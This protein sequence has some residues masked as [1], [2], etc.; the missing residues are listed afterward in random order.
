[1][2]NNIG[3]IDATICEL[4]FASVISS[5]SL[6]VRLP[7]NLGL[8]RE[9]FWKSFQTLSTFI[10]TLS[11]L[12]RTVDHMSPYQLK[13]QWVINRIRQFGRNDGIHPFRSSEMMGTIEEDDEMYSVCQNRSS[14]WWFCIDSSVSQDVGSL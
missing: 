8:V 3:V 9:R 2:S 10:Q 4:D 7:C 12:A 11:W 14:V 13:E 6:H 5:L 1:M